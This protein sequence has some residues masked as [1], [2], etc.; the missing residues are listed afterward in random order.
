MGLQQ[1]MF[2]FWMTVFARFDCESAILLLVSYVMNHP[3]NLD[4]FPRVLTVYNL[5]SDGEMLI[6]RRNRGRL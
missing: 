4:G 3:R 2:S 6:C 1:V 5:L